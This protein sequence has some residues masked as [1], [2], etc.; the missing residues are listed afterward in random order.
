M[1]PPHRTLNTEIQF[2]ER[3]RRQR[4]QRVA[5]ATTSSVPA[6]AAAARAMAVAAL[7]PNDVSGDV[8]YDII[9]SRRHSPRCARSW[10]STLP[11]TGTMGRVGMIEWGLV[12]LRVLPLHICEKASR[13][14][15]AGG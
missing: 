9:R 7:F 14:Q 1:P 12:G 15:V 6:S 5:A 10:C 11:T 13:G 4:V 3:R 8:T 2:S